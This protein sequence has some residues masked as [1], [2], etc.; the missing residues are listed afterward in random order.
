MSAMINDNDNFID[1]YQTIS[2]ATF[3]F[4]ADLP[5]LV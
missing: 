4:V 2:A 5:I 1:K 3:A